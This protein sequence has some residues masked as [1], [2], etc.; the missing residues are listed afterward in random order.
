MHFWSIHEVALL[1]KEFAVN[2]RPQRILTE[3]VGEALL[4]MMNS[5][6]SFQSFR[7]ANILG[8]PPTF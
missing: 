5:L 3:Y 7:C 2:D 4:L 6:W 1:R 8:F